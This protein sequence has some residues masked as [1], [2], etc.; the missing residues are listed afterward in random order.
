M[1]ELPQS[2][3]VEEMRCGRKLELLQKPD[4][5]LAPES[6]GREQ[7]QRNS[8]W[9]LETLQEAEAEAQEAET[10]PGCAC[11]LCRECLRVS[12]L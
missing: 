7:E 12:V 6:V 9:K 3:N 5:E 8:S 1:Q 10:D 4:P 2:R 11:L